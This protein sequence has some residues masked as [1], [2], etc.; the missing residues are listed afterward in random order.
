MLL[1]CILTLLLY[2]YFYDHYTS[3]DE[4]HKNILYTGSEYVESG[5]NFIVIFLLL[6][7]LQI[8]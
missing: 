3:L 6:L 7:L 2:S 1:F 8:Y 4:F 5:L